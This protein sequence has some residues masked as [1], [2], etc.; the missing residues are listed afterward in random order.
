MA[1][2]LD[3]TRG[4]LARGRAVF[5]ARPV[6]AVFVLTFAGLLV[7]HA[8]ALF[9]PPYWDG[10]IGAFPQGLWLARHDFD[11]VRLLTEERTCPEGGPNVYPFSIYPIA[12]GA[13][14]SAGLEPRQVFLLVHLAM[15]VCAASAAAA[16]FALARTATDPRT[17]ARATL[18]F[19]SAPMFHAMASQMNMDM[20]L[21]ACTLLSA[22]AM[23]TGRFGRAAAFAAVALLVLPRGVIVVVANLVLLGAW[24][25]GR[26]RDGDAPNASRRRAWNACGAHVGLLLLFGIELV[27]ASRWSRGPAYVSLFGGFGDLARR[28]LWIVPDVGWAFV[29]A[30]IVAVVVT[31]L[32]WRRKA[33]WTELV[34][35]SFV[36][37]FLAF[38]GQYT[39]TLPRY[40]LQVHGHVLVLLLAFVARDGRNV[41]VVRPW[42]A[43]A[44]IAQAV[45][46][47]GTFYPAVSTGWRVPG[48]ADA[49]LRSN[50]G[51][52]LERSMEYRD[53][54]L[55]DAEI[56]R[57]LERFDRARTL[58]VAPWPITHALAFPEL[59]YVDRA[60]RTSSPSV[61]ITF[62]PNATPLRDVYDAGARPPRQRVSLEVVWVLVPSVYLP[63]ALA[64]EPSIDVVEEVVERGAHRAF[65]VR[66]VGWNAR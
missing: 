23:Q 36:L 61:P 17:G 29:G 48:Y 44:A 18:V 40:F 65:V 66:R 28:V 46:H 2:S 5:V 41:R 33:R 24:L 53:D 22:R 34:S 27:L 25:F 39:N 35:A 11:L 31:G 3:D 9:D 37:V 47:F 38:F 16:F 58:V 51:H 52:V 59:G 14:Y 49:K 26:A 1:S 6:A 19:A 42:L 8:R 54:L 7:L 45:N 12:I 30:V 21:C 57:R 13:L 32:A 62:D 15:L 55:L 63:G 56:A 64:L 10:L 4:A 43:L 20:P 50:D 60:W